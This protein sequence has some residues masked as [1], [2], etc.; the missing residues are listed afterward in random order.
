MKNFILYFI[1]LLLV[2]CSSFRSIVSYKQVSLSETKTNIKS[3]NNVIPDKP[4]SLENAIQIALANNPDVI[5]EKHETDASKFRYEQAVNQKLPIVKLQSGYNYHLDKQRLAAASG[6]GDPGIYSNNI[7]TGDLILSVPLFTGG[8][9]Q[10]QIEINKL[11]QQSSEYKFS[12]TE[13]ELVFNISSMFYTILA[14]KHVIESLDFSKK[15]LEEHV[16]RIQ[17]LI[18]VQKAAEVDLL[19]TEVRLANINQQLTRE[20]NLLN[21]QHRVFANLLGLSDNS[22]KLIL[23]GSL[24]INNQYEIPDTKK[25]FETAYKNRN[26][27]LAAKLNLEVQA[28]KID[29]TN[30]EF[31]PDIFFQSS[32][33]YRWAFDSNGSTENNLEDIGKIGIAIELPLF[34]KS[35][36]TA[37]LNEQKALLSAAQQKFRKLKMQI[38]LEIET[39]LLNLNSY[40]KQIEAL[41]KYIQQAEESLRI[42]KQKYNIGKGT[43]VDV[44]DAQ[45]ALLEVQ[46]NYYKVSAQFKIALAELK[47][48]KGE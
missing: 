30:S 17:D 24:K 39:V 43:I 46:Q 7:I 45:S 20:K 26:D 13:Q 9:I 3:D 37:K 33:G 16:K 12:Q 28:K 42:E 48:V 31:L 14:Q 1:I 35:K 40:Y 2:G 44:F 4:L 32:Y 36:I 19:R 27:Y 6:S 21:I 18:S 5:A 25:I 22:E 11:L 15:T 38:K 47:L 8:K 29:L 10:R 34:N 23:E 41:S